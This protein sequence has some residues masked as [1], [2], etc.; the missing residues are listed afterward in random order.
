MKISGTLE[1]PSPAAICQGQPRSLFQGTR[2]THFRPVGRSRVTAGHMHGCARRG[3]WRSAGWTPE[4]TRLCQHR[5]PGN[6]VDEGGG[7]GRGAWS[8]GP[9]AELTLA[10]RSTGCGKDSGRGACP[11]SGPQ[12]VQLRGLA[13]FIS[14]PVCPRGLRREHDSSLTYL[15]VLLRGLSVPVS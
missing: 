2:R 3:C 11:R 8:G 10:G 14:V 1:Q 4:C 7:N 6:E 9:P 15:V 13:R 5:T 12:H